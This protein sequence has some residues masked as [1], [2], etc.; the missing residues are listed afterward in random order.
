MT[1]RTRA[2]WRRVASDTPFSARHVEDAMA[3]HYEADSVR[4]QVFALA[5]ALAIVIACLGLFGLAAFAVERRK[6]E[7]AVRKVFGARDRDVAAL[8]VFQFSRPVLLANLLAWPVAWWLMRDW[9]NGFPERIELHPGWFVGAGALALLIAALTVSG[10]AWRA[11]R[12][13]PAEALRNE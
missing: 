2:I 5:A 7:I 13:R 12:L 9:L 6:L 4:G 8:M 10:H 1:G 3:E 11:S